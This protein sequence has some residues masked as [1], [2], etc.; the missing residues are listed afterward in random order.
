MSSLVA[1]EKI[2]PPRACDPLLI[3]RI[4]Q[5]NGLPPIA[6]A[7]L[8][9]RGMIDPALIQAFL[10]PS[11]DH[12]HDPF[13]FKDMEKAVDRI[14]RAIR[15]QEKIC[16]HGDYDV[17]G[18]TSSAL[19]L[20]FLK[21]H[22]ASVDYYI[23]HRL[24]EGYGLSESG[25]RQ[26]HQTG[27]TLILTVDCGITAP[28]E[29]ALAEELGMDVILTDHHLP[30][31]VL[32]AAYAVI[33][34]KVPDCG[35]PD[36]NLAG[37]GVAFKLVQALHQRLFPGKGMSDIFHFLDL[38]SIGTAADIVPL[39]GENRAF[40]KAG[41]ERLKGSFCEGIK[42][43]LRL[44]GLYD[45]SISTGQIVFQIAPLINAAGRLSH[46]AK[47]VEFFLT[48]DPAKAA[49]LAEELKKNNAERRGID[50]L[51]TDECFEA[52]ESGVDL[53]KTFFIV[54][55]SETWHAGV[56]GI[57][58]SRIVERYARPAML[59]CVEGETGRGSARSVPGLH[60]IEAIRA[61]ADLVEEYG[62]HEYAAGVTLP[63]G[64]IETFRQR[65]NE[66]ALARLK[67]EDLVRTVRTDA[68]VE[69]LEDITWELLRCLKR[70]EPHGPE[71]AKP[72]LYARGLQVVGA[73]R[74]VGNNH[75]K[76]KVRGKRAVFDAIAFKMGD[77]LAHVSEPG[78]E[79][80]LAFTLEENEW[81]GEKTLQFNV[82]GIE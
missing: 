58:A 2:L 36:S 66:F 12:L 1:R 23:P 43:L 20:R 45:K 64:N 4:S 22:A 57:V 81:L 39:L 73:P 82:R 27:A 35:Y 8:C 67:P 56:V 21:A 3:E 55:A 24:S 49:A 65:L 14:I 52:I 9:G 16:V 13:L 30:Q 53:D 50:Q 40:V 11:L 38:V 75:L 71:N 80:T 74:I 29:V 32:P 17:D 54:L 18:I 33:N 62:G 34:P 60:V 68:S 26:I 61:S 42:V 37:V 76:F 7:V 72:I 44:S 41:L 31:E 28:A 63:K 10:T 48:E 51:I 6:A 25:I 5:E 79:L 70:F 15:D 46:P 47:C 59:I 78:R 69:S 19:L 77:R